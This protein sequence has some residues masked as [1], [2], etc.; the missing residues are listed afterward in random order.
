[1]PIGFAIAVRSCINHGHASDPKPGLTGDAVCGEVTRGSD[2]IRAARWAVGVAR[3]ETS[4]ERAYGTRQQ[5]STDTGGPGTGLACLSSLLGFIDAAR[6]C[7][8]FW[9]SAVGFEHKL[10]G[11]CGNPSAAR[12]LAP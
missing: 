3:C 12:P 2:E 6:A 7:R 1:M 9:G 10:H 5:V 4:H 8:V 11:S